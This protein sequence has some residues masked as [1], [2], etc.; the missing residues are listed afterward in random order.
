MDKEYILKKLA[1]IDK[2]KFG[3]LE[4]GLFGSYSRDEQTEDSDI[5]ILVKM[6]FGQKGAYSR[7]CDLEIYL[8]EL[9][10]KKV[11]LVDKGVFEY[12][13]KN[14]KVKEYKENVK[15]QILESVIYV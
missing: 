4:I 9:F 7:F 13:F 11:D 2:K 6:D 3:I 5:D 8:K 14:P 15:K 12:K 10:G 1:E